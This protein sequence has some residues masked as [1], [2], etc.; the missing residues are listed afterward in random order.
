MEELCGP[1]LKLEKQDF[2]AHGDDA[3]GKGDFQGCSEFNPVLIFSQKDQTEFER[4]KD[5][6]A[7]DEANASNRRV[8]VLIFRK[9]S[10]VDPSKWPCPRVNEGVA[11]CRKRFWS[12]GEQRRSK[13]LADNPRKFEET[14]DT[15]ACR[16]YQRLTSDSPCEHLFGV[17]RIR[18][19]DGFGEFIPLAPFTTSAAEAPPKDEIGRADARGVI[20]LRDLPLPSQQTIRWGFPPETGEDAELMFSRTVFL[21]SDDDRSPEAS[22]NRL[23]NLGYDGPSEEDNIVGF[24]LDYGSLVDPPLEN[25]G[26]FDDRTRAL[27]DEVH[28]QSADRLRDTT[29]A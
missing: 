13:R 23:K 25:T 1:E 27:V 14:L 16:F 5:K 17:L 7:R 26:E 19:Y 22:R 28:R 2:L 8:V 21:M 9:G 12:D 15:F 3:G 24:Q 29:L 20:A 11:G 18:L 10:R 6:T 4:D